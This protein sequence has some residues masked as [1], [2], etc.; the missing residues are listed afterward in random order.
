MA[1]VVCFFCERIPRIRQNLRRLCLG[2]T[3][4]TNALRSCDASVFL[5]DIDYAGDLIE[6]FEH[7]KDDP[8]WPKSCGGCGYQFLDSDYWQVSSNFVYRNPNT[9]EILT[10]YE[11]PPGSLYRAHWHEDIKHWTG[12]DGFSVMC[13]LPNKCHWLIDGPSRDSGQQKSWSRSGELPRIS[14]SPS[15]QAEDYHGYLTDGV[16]RSC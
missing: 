9:N 12:P 8:L 4:P 14:V 7:P 5:R 15:I 10:E 11:L 3:C 16:L 13:V 1:E 2:R 6:V